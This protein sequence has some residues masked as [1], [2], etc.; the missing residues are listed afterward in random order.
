MANA[1]DLIMPQNQLLIYLH[2]R[3]AEK[4]TWIMFDEA[5]QKI[6]STNVLLLETCPKPSSAMQVIVLFPTTEILL[7]KINLPPTK[8]SQQTT[9]ALFALEEKL[10]EEVENLH[11]IVMHTD[12]NNLCFVGIIR[13]SLIEQW[14]KQ[15]QALALTPSFLLPDMLILP[16][17]EQTWT[18]LLSEDTMLVRTGLYQ[19]FSC[20][21]ENYKTFSK[22]QPPPEIKTQKKISLTNFLNEIEKKPSFFQT[23]NLLQGKYKP[24]TSWYKT[25]ESFRLPVLF[26]M[27]WLVLC[28][29]LILAKIITL[30]YQ[31]HRLEKQITLLYQAAYPNA[32][33]VGSPQARMTQEMAQ[34]TRDEKSQE[35]FTLLAILQNALKQMPTIRIESFNFRDNTL[36][37]KIQ[38]PNFEQLEKFMKQLT[39]DQLTVKQNDA[40]RTEENITA[41]LS[42]T[43]ENLSHESH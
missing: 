2:D 6:E 15:L 4:A 14:Q 27:S 3:E 34:L 31:N 7:T 26:G 10:A 32:A 22:I 12:E 43:R 1:R 17:E 37:L 20:T 13:Q 41:T 38:T 21:K 42:I 36:L 16:H 5:G 25:Q 23:F 8:K 9:A 19:G 29:L 30:T 33:D 18:T 40:A 11:G 28:I 35:A 39:Q 24:K